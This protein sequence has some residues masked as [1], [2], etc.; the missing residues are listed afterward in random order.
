MIDSQRMATNAGMEA[1]SEMPSFSG[2]N[3]T[4]HNGTSQEDGETFEIVS[5]FRDDLIMLISGVLVGMLSYYDHHQFFHHN[6]QQQHNVFYS[7]NIFS[8]LE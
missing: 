7:L 8:N 6:P 3:S 1:R 2:L 4:N 5:L